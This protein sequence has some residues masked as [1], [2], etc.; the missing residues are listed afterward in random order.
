[1]IDKGFFK[2]TPSSRFGK[3]HTH[4]CYKI[5]QVHSRPKSAGSKG[6]SDQSDH[7]CLDGRCFIFVNF[8]KIYTLCLK[9]GLNF[10]VYWNN[11]LS[12]FLIIFHMPKFLALYL[13]S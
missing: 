11:L 1:M 9:N 6:F 13:Q 4:L 10:G 3:N 7:R 12:Y 2:N 5:Y 8:L